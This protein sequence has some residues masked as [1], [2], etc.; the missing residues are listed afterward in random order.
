MKNHCSATVR[1]SIARVLSPMW[2]CSV[3]EVLMWRWLS[4]H[5]P[6]KKQEFF[7]TFDCFVFFYYYFHFYNRLRVVSCG[8]VS[9]RVLSFRIVLFFVLLSFNVMLYC[10]CV[11]CSVCFVFI[12][13]IKYHVLRFMVLYRTFCLWLLFCFYCTR[14]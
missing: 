11:L 1:A 6:K 8:I 2:I 14:N 4:S 9:R 3:S 10:I 5:S 13:F 12:V 7:L